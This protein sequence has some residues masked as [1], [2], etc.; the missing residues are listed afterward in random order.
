M[1]F[2]IDLRLL[3]EFI[4]IVDKS[5]FYKKFNDTFKTKVMLA[6][7]SFFSFYLMII[8][9]ED[10]YKIVLKFVKAINDYESNF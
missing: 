6:S 9:I 4:V 3:H 1:S 7:I 10:D 2:C 5:I 8:I